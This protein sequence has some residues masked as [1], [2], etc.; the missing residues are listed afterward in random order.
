ME[1]SQIEY[2]D[3]KV[4][5][6]N[7]SSNFILWDLIQI[8]TH[9]SWSR[10]SPYPWTVSMLIKVAIYKAFPDLKDVW[11]TEQSYSSS[12]KLRSGTLN[13]DLTLSPLASVLSLLCWAPALMV[14]S[15]SGEVEPVRRAL[16]GSRLCCVRLAGFSMEFCLMVWKWKR[17]S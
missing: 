16:L 13:W 12:G 4:A 8:K 2:C 14:F 15:V 9:H 3:P 5:A 10:I 6:Y 7:I 17:E 11:Q 1:T